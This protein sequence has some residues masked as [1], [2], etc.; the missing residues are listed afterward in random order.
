[1]KLLVS[2]GFSSKAPMF[3]QV[4]VLF[5]CIGKT[6]RTLYFQASSP[7][8]SP[9]SFLVWRACSLR[10]SSLEGIGSQGLVSRPVCREV[11]GFKGVSFDEPH[12]FE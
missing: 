4:V 12:V 8:V 11:I 10:T 3:E 5:V 6:R 1:M 7:T 9:S 2:M